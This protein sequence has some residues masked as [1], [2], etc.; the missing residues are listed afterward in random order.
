MDFVDLALCACRLPVTEL[1]GII[2]RP[3]F[4]DCYPVTV[5]CSFDVPVNVLTGCSWNRRDEIPKT[6]NGIQRC[7][8]GKLFQMNSMCGGRSVYYYAGRIHSGKHNV[9]VWR[10]SVRPSV[11]ILNR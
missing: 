3:L 1:P 4:I 8:C 5:I 2:R 6:E 7:R 11:C 9:T 10:Q